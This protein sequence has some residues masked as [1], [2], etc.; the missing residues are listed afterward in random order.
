LD[1]ANLALVDRTVALAVYA[2]ADSTDTPQWK[3]LPQTQR[4]IKARQDSLGKK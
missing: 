1:Y 3:D 2:V 4:Y